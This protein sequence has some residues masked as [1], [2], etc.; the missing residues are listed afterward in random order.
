MSTLADELIEQLCADAGAEA[1][2]ACLETLSKLMVNT[3]KD[4]A[5][6]KFRRVRTGNAVLARTVFA[7]PQ[8][9]LLL[10]AFGFVEEVGGD[11]EG[12]FV[13]A[14]GA[15][16]DSGVL[17]AVV[18][19]ALRT[20]PPAA[21]PAPAPGAAPSAAD[22]ARKAALEAAR[23]RHASEELERARVRAM[24]AQDKAARAARAETEVI[25]ASVAAPRLAHGS[26]TTFG[27]VGVNL[28][29]KGG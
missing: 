29:A 3:R 24:I 16:G 27:D 15:A 6:V 8:A 11:G 5:N 12:A 25:R 28:N 18:R 4:P 7:Y 10:S 23:A 13:L 26:A 17:Q 21:A 9:E 2:H 22:E 20:A 1:S 19:A 14:E